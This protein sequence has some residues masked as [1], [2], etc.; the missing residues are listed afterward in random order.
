MG[1]T[2]S[3]RSTLYSKSALREIGLQHPFSRIYSSNKAT[4]ESPSNVHEKGLEDIFPK[5]KVQDIIMSS[6]VGQT[7]LQVEG[8]NC[9]I[10]TGA[11]TEA[12]E[13]FKMITKERARWPKLV[14][15]QNHMA[16]F[17]A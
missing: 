4:D 8:W 9:Q 10:F 16:C 14:K 11:E 7:S 5:S 6:R 1:S 2:N 17:L 3:H 12:I 13:D 15:D